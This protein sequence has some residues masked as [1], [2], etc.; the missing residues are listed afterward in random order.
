M[1]EIKNTFISGK[2]NKDLD[3]RLVPSGEYRDALNVDIATSESSNTGVVENSF[4][5]T[6]VSAL[7]P[8]GSRCVGVV[9]YAREDR[10]YWLVAG[11][12]PS[13]GEQGL[14]LIIEYHTDEI[15]RAHV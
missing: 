7:A 8:S 12:V 15:G 3:E 14:D 4:G 1:P 9:N 2:M 6:V 13:T 5:N 11:P 10:I